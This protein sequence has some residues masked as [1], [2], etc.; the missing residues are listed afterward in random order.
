MPNKKIRC[1]KF[2]QGEY[3]TDWLLQS[4][5]FENFLKVHGISNQKAQISE[6]LK[7]SLQAYTESPSSFYMFIEE[8]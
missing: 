5:D 3:V 7:K 1:I 2:K 8:D 6:Q 4:E